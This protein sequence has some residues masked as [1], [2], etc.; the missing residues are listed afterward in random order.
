[1]LSRSLGHRA[2]LLWLVL[3]YMAGLT[4]GHLGWH[5]PI[6]PT[7]A[8]AVTGVVIAF[9]AGGKRPWLWALGLSVALFLAAVVHYQ[10][11]RARLPVWRDLPP[12]EAQLTVRVDHMFA[13]KDP[14]RVSGLGRVVDTENHLQELRGQRLYFSLH[15]RAGETAP[16]RSTE[17]AARGVLTLLPDN[18]P[19]DSFD[20]YLTNA[21]MNFRL[22]RGQ[23]LATVKPA[24]A[25]YRFCAATVVRFRTI[26]HL[27]IAEKQPTLAGLLSAMLLGETNDLSDEQRDLF[28]QSGTM[29]LFAIS[30]LNIGVIAAALQALLMLIRLPR[31]VRVA[32]SIALLWLFVDIT[33]AS[34][35]AVRAFIMAA[36]LQ[37]AFLLKKPASPLA[38]L[39]ASAALVLLLTPLQLFSASFQMSYGIVLALLL[40]GLPLGEAWLARWTPWRDLPTATWHWWQSWLDSG[41]RA[42]AAAVAIG[43]AT[44]LVSLLTSVQFFQLLTPIALLAN[45]VL[46]PTAVFATLGGFAA[47]VCG[48]AGLDGLAAFF[49]HAAALTLQI[50]EW[51]VRLSVQV[52]GAHQ[53]AHYTTPGLGPVALVLLLAAMLHGYATRWAWRRGGWAPPLVIAA[54]VLIF[55]VKFG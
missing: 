11:Q 1:M 48:L 43:V 31:L 52:P 35:S 34:A 44:T 32:A 49:N 29:H 47:L 19:S 51:L 37:A 54:L 7:L 2:P 16:L 25:Y 38:A 20:Y 53:T 26:L 39:V 46:I 24:T 22:N 8:G 15:L 18:P 21:G 6:A 41:W 13:Q 55:G 30:G 50:I 5:W 17:I 23:I 4:A 9:F 27:G 14:R 12:R 10:L 42:L 28:M 40:M 33:G 36:F 45:L 3:P